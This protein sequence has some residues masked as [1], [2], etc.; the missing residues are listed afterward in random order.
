M[1]RIHKVRSG[2]IIDK[3][4]FWI[5]IPWLRMPHCTRKYVKSCMIFVSFYINQCCGSALVSMR[6]QISILGQ[7]RSGSRVLKTKNWTI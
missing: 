7:C 6:I 4:K 2:T 3:T 5:R 1:V